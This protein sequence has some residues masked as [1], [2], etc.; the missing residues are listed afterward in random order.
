MF[1]IVARRLA[2]A[3]KQPASLA[4]K[5]S[6]VQATIVAPQSTNATTPTVATSRTENESRIIEASEKTI[7]QV[8]FI[9]AKLRKGQVFDF[10]QSIFCFLNEKIPFYSQLDNSI[11]NEAEI[12]NRTWT[13]LLEESISLSKFAK[14]Q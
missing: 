2:L 4:K 1:S 6:G 7:Q 14:S 12:R 11:L 9:H 3:S 13:Q 5:S 10:P 8:A